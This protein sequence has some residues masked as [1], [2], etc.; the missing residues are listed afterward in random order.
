VRGGSKKKRV[1]RR[2]IEGK[3]A[4]IEED[5]NGTRN[6]EGQK[7]GK[8]KKKKEEEGEEEEGARVEGLMPSN[9]RKLP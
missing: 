1:G 8:R 2:K 4:H 5:R 7:G 3:R 9:E 6:E